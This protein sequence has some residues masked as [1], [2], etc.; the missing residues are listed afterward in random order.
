MKWD[1]MP[2]DMP[3]GL[4]CGNRVAAFGLALLLLPMLAA[5]SPI[6]HKKKP[7]PPLGEI[8][9]RMN[10]SAK[11]LKTVSANLEFTKVT[12][13]VNDKATEYGELY[14]QKGKNGA[15]LI[16]FQKPEPKEVLVHAEAEE[17][18]DT[19]FPTVIKYK[20]LISRSTAAWSNSSCCLGLEQK[21]VISRSL[22]AL[23]W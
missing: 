22:T 10:E 2:I 3:G 19:T 14:F 4:R 18:R 1:A 11:R 16:N 17:G 13:V 6:H 20:N 15:V 23:N 7:A 5:A 12:V 21:S 9:G 8:L